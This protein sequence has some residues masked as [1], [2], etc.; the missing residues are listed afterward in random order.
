M[1]KV[2]I[3]PEFARL[4]KMLNKEQKEAV[5]SI[6]G[7]V[8]VV[9]G[10]GTGK[11]Q[12]LTLRIANIL[13][14]TDTTPDSIL[15]LTF[16]EAG[17]SAMKRRLV[18]IIG[19]DGYKVPIYTYH[20]FCNDVIKKYPDEFPRIIGSEPIT[21]IEQI[22]ILRDIIDKSDWEHLKP[23]GDNYYFLTDIRSQISELKR[24]AIDVDK[25][26]KNLISNK[27]EILSSDDLFHSKG[28]WK[29]KMKGKYAD[30]IKRTERGLELADMYEMYEA[31][32]RQRKLYD[33]EDMILEVTNKLQEDGSLL[34]KLQEQYL[35]ILADEHQDANGAQNQ[36][37]QMLSDYHESPNLF[38]V[39]DEKQAIYRFQGAS[40]ENFNYFK[41][42]YPEA[43]LVNLKSNYRSGQEILDGASCLM[44]GISEQN[45]SL[46]AK[47][48][49]SKEKTGITLREFETPNNELIWLARDIKDKI[50]KGVEPGEI[51]VLYRNNSDAVDVSL[52][53]QAESVSHKVESNQNALEDI[54]MRKLLTVLFAVAEFGSSSRIVKAMHISFLGLSPTTV[55]RILRYARRER[56]SV[57]EVLQKYAKKA[58]A[59]E[60][61]V[62]Q[63]MDK[64]KDLSM[65][66]KDESVPV[67]F[68][69][70]VRESGFL[71]H[72]LNSRRS[73][74]LVEKLRALSFVV[75]ELARKDKDYSI[76]ALVDHLQM[77]EEYNV[78]IKASI[79][80]EY[81]SSVR[82]MTAHRAKGLEFEYVYIIGLNDGH[83]GN[84]RNTDLFKLPELG[85]NKGDNNDERRLFY[86]ALTRGKLWVN[87][88]Y[89]RISKTER[90]QM[91]S[92]FLEEIKPE[93]YAKEDVSSFENKLT[94]EDVFKSAVPDN[95][96][97]QDK[98]YLNGLFREF[99]LSVTA[100][101]NYLECPWKYFYRNLVRIPEPPSKNLSL[102]NAAHSA[103]QAYHELKPSTVKQANKI[104]KE[105]FMRALEKEPVSQ[106]EFDEISKIGLESLNSWI[107]NYHGKLHMR[108]KTEMEMNVNL[109]TE[110]KNL[111]YVLLRGK[112]DKVELHESD[113]V[114]VVDYKTG[115]PKSR[116]D[117]LGKTK[118]SNGNYYRQLV[119]YKLM[120]DLNNE[121]VRKSGK[122][123]IYNI[124]KGV[125]DFIQPDKND[126]MH[127]E[128]FEVDAEEVEALKALILKVSKEI[129]DLTFWNSRCDKHKEGKCQYCELR[130]FMK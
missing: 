127:K 76:N 70:L 77:L 22:S 122:G 47:G 78:P 3:T 85:A 109:E 110:Q 45:V 8:M 24:E 69:T 129:L 30:A 19:S 67:F 1:S 21:D 115:Q 111:T 59:D 128:E 6:E 83:W 25:L 44:Q 65:K 117:I 57:F 55:Y 29:G 107:D 58:G 53:L 62:E 126:K 124:Q 105:T 94:P 86:V 15:A 63:F 81:S 40:L 75:T 102:G 52:A 32:L 11:T 103:L 60:R 121:E 34:L 116:N 54:E 87:L 120:L 2:L 16:T 97:I 42:L 38:I 7:P 13:K 14:E 130:D 113:K 4:Y 10:P 104:I 18:S 37:L 43:K 50:Q 36:I 56:K 108:V 79:K 71:T 74:E 92:I 101:N 106:S 125:V 51:A 66:A 123:R 5:D 112:L 90:G 72:I 118:S 31:E 28:K 12:I 27:E 64:L 91:P 82:L 68:N 48:V 80:A 17:V 35:Y 61:E 41:K 20:G 100:L 23:F 49:Y 84:K 33:Y 119:F 96:F 46:V 114:V 89:S 88:S 39:G 26:R 93:L 9:A 99:G 95:N 98:E 73:G